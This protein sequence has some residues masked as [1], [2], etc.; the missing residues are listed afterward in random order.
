MHVWYLTYIYVGSDSS[1]STK[2]SVAMWSVALL[3]PP[4]T[5]DTP[6]ALFILP[7][8]F[9]CIF[10]RNRLLLLQYKC[11]RSTVTVVHTSIHP[12]VRRHTRTC[13]HTT[14]PTNGVGCG[15][16]PRISIFYHTSCCC[17]LHDDD[18][19]GPTS[20]SLVLV[21][22]NFSARGKQAR[23]KVGSDIVSIKARGRR[24]Y[25]K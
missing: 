22:V 3:R 21:K 23:W 2:L 18:T 7:F 10:F 25:N 9:P 24:A 1:S 20:H 13:W 11:S 6:H 14:P 16:P 19:G 15:D 12:A 8:H 5:P 17:W 4:R